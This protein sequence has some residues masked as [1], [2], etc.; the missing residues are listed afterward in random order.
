MA[1]WFSG[2]KTL[3]EEVDKTAQQTFQVQ[4]QQQEADGK[5]S[6]LSILTYSELEGRGDALS[7]YEGSYSSLIQCTGLQE[8]T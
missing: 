3:L 8:R 1:T 2:L 5:E 7:R 6:V 4:E